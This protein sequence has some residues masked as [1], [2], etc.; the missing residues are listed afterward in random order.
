MN[1]EH[2]DPIVNAVVYEGHILY[3]YR[4]SSLKNRRRFTFGRVYPHTFALAEEGRERWQMTSE[5][6]IR[7]LD[8]DRT[9]MLDVRLRF[10]HPVER[11]VYRAVTS[12]GGKP[13]A[14]SDAKVRL[15]PV[16]NLVLNGEAY[17]SWQEV[18]EETVDLPT[19]ALD[20]SCHARL[21]FSFR[22]ETSR[23]DIRQD[24]EL[25]GA[26]ERRR[27]MIVGTLELS[28]EKIEP[29]LYKV[30]V[31]I[32]NTTAL[33]HGIPENEDELLLRTMAS[34]HTV[35]QVRDARFLSL[36]DPPGPYAAQAK[37]CRKDG[38]WPVLV[39]EPGRDDTMLSSP[40]I[41]YDYP[42]VAPE[43]KGDFFDST[44]ID[45]LLS[46]RVMTM[47][48]EEKEEMRSVDDF[49]RRI[50][51]RANSMSADDLLDMHG[52]LREW[53]ERAESA[54][55]DSVDIGGGRGRIGDR[56]RIQPRRR[57]DGP[58]ARRP[59]GRD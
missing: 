15:R 56:V 7:P 37:N 26:V 47:T 55:P 1:T 39:G 36:T 21:D 30:T 19:A 4:P 27:E 10:L 40:I 12:A 41:L 54:P 17:H 5:V 38:T 42:E 35:L 58:V 33:E 57:A 51:Q 43:S 50:L 25:V 31:T 20:E 28:A 52:T 32:S 9:P 29:G 16:P 46:L 14:D 49:A 13:G 44:E 53:K 2:V 48:D 6:L 22:P 18:E 45:E 23:E 3:P 34:T 59:C 8:A 24:D 11:Q